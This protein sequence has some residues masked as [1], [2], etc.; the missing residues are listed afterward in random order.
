MTIS[1]NDDKLEYGSATLT[2][3]YVED[4]TCVG[5]ETSDCVEDFRFFK[6]TKSEG[7]DLDGILGMSPISD[8]ADLSLINA[9]AY[10]KIIDEAKATFCLNFDG[11]E[12]SYVTFGSPNDSCRSEMRYSLDLDNKND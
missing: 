2:G 5:L 12:E 10:K 3:E 6:I 4:T 1:S 8:R 9:L 11:V 7:F